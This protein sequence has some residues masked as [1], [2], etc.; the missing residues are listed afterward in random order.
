[1][2]AEAGVVWGEELYFDATKIEANAS[3]ESIVPRFAV[4][5]HLHDYSRKTHETRRI[6][7]A[8]RASLRRLST[9]FRHPKTRTSPPPT[10]PRATG[11]PRRGVK[12][13]KK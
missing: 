11:S 7:P 12:T 8:P 1:M 10:P 5:H 3:L 6:R 9:C 13:A 4:E 2:C